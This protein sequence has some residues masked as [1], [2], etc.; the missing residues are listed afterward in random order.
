MK[1]QR[2]HWEKMRLTKEGKKNFWDAEIEK[3]MQNM[4]Q[5]FLKWLSTKDDND[6]VQYK[7]AQAK[8]RRMVTNH[9]NEFWDKKC[10]EIQSYLGSKKSS[11]S[12]KFIKKI[13][14]HQ[15]VVTANS[16]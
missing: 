14:I 16:T 15:M 8:I 5:L 10:S 6:K 2:K 4:K 1:Q 12:W 11:D 7:N 3:E 9:R 13:Y